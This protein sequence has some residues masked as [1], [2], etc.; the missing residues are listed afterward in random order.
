MTPSLA[1][2]RP[3][4]LPGMPRFTGG[5]V[6]Y[7]G[8][9]YITRIEPSVPAAPRDELGIPMVYFMLSDSLLIFD[10]AKQT[11]RLCVNAHVRPPRDGRSRLRSRR[12]RAPQPLRAAPPAS[13]IGPCP[14]CRHAGSTYRLATSP[15]TTMR[16]WSTGEGIHPRR[17]HHP[18]SAVPTVQHFPSIAPRSIYIARCVRST[19]LR[20][21]LSSIR[22]ILPSSEPPRRSM[23]D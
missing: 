15:G 21:C 13:R 20:T 9:E 19:R 7:I 5:A 11:L 6:G 1:G 2:H 17:R 23:C 3:V 12:P 4:K 10:R 14:A 18:G 22:V 8:Y 16:S